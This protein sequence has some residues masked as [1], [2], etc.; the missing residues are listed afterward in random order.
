MSTAL[1]PGRSRRCCHCRRTSACASG[2][3]GSR[4]W[5][6]FSACLLYGNTGGLPFYR[7]VADII[8]ADITK[9][10]WGQDQYTLLSAYAGMRPAVRLFGPEIA[11]V[12]KDKP[13]LF[14]FTAS[15]A[16]H[17]LQTD[18]SGYARAFRQ[19]AVPVN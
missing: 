18:Q 11:S 12:D 4:P 8:R 6:Q 17:N 2:V 10:W 15:T 3:G 5:H 16:K 19:F 14:W 9:A 13:G 7:R 1:S